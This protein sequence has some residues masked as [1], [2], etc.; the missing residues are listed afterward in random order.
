MLHAG[1]SET[2]IQRH[3]AAI[4]DTKAL[5]R[6]LAHADDPIPLLR[7][8]L[9]V[10]HEYLDTAFRSGAQVEELVA[11]RARH[12]DWILQHWWQRFQ[13]PALKSL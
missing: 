10:L 4:C 2:D 1:V 11:T 5:S 7:Q 9:K 8:Q 13:W 12:M 3:L 6:S